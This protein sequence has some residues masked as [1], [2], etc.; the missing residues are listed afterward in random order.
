[1]PEPEPQTHSELASFGEEL[2]RE[3]E[4]RAISLKEIADATKI[5]KRFLDAIERNDHKTLP[6]PVFTRG[7][8]REYARY[9][10]LNA[11]E[12]VN[13][14]NYAAAG[15]DRIE[16]SAHLD[17]L[18]PKP[19]DAPVAPPKRGIPS[20]LA[21]VDRNIYLFLLVTAAL[22]AVIWWAVARKREA[23]NEETRVVAPVVTAKPKRA[24]AQPAENA[25]AAAQ[26]EIL[27]LTVD[28]NDNSW[29]QL[30]ADGVSVFNDEMKRGDHRVFDAK[31]QFR[32]KTIGNA[33]GPKLSLNGVQ[34]PPLG[35]EGKV[36]HDRVFDRKTLTEV[37][38]DSNRSEP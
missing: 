29:I 18:T 24:P 6:A 36:L 17:R 12:M 32:F 28:M 25:T 13:R 33:A 15:D 31:N 5:S 37:P 20:P 8:V 21:R 35:R 7:F 3:R 38:A 1:M 16:K 30:E 14:Y 10:G 34:I 27:H 19:S 11:E 4:I 2:R 23:R 9:L 26:D 22:A